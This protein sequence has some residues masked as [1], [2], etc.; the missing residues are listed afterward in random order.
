MIECLN[1][2][3]LVLEYA[4]IDKMVGKSTEELLN[5]LKFTFV[6]DP[7]STLGCVQALLRCIFG[8][9]SA[10]QMSTNQEAVANTSSIVF[11]QNTGMY[12]SCFDQPYNELVHT[13]HLARDSTS[14]PDRS[15]SS[16]FRPTSSSS[17]SL[18][19]WSVSSPS[20]RLMSTALSYN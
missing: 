5:Y 6:L 15:D 2:L 14:T 7:L 20:D 3:S 1:C 9:N 4:P 17:S 19:S 18:L 16:L 10:N 12:Y 8:T 13:F 11:S